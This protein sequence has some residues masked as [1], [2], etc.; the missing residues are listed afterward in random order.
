MWKARTDLL[1]HRAGEQWL[2]IDPRNDSVHAL[3]ASAFWIWRSCD[4]VLSEQDLAE[5]VA[6]EIQQPV[7][8]VVGGVHDTLA[9]L[10]SLGLI[11]PAT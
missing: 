2:L 1:P 5:R 4:G 9:S 10:K 11:E 3:N 8:T 7:N 6:D